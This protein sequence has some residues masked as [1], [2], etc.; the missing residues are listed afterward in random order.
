MIRFRRE[1]LKT[2]AA[3]ATFASLPAQAAGAASQFGEIRRDDIV[4]LFDNLPGDLGLKI[5]AP[6]LKGKHGFTVQANA[7]KVL[8]AASAIKTFALCEALRQAD[9]PDIV[10]ALEAKELP[11]DAS[12]WSLG[13]PIFEPPDLSGIVSERTALEAMVLRSDNTAT[14]MI[15]NLAGADNIRKFIASAG[16]LQT[17]VPDNTRIFSGYL[18]GADNYKTITWDQLLK[19]APPKG[20]IVHPFLN[21]VETLASTAEDFVTYYSQ[22]LPGRFFQ[23]SETLQEFRR[24]LTLCDFIYLVPVPLGVSAYAKSGNVDTARFH[25]RTLAGGMFFDD[26]WVYF[27][28]LLNWYAPEGD[29]PQTV[30]KFFAAIHEALTRVTEAL[31]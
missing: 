26:R 6:S 25:A 9:S 12:V 8:F 13:S 29:D 16:L 31:S 24:I 22:A 15:F 10:D 18:F 3:T 1:F 11:L 23:H 5:Y 21:D 17:R 7:D 2:A 19:L 14:D 4:P 20:R 27:A 30:R 28:F